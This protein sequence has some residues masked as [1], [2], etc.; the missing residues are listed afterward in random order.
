M[1]KNVDV[2]CAENL[3]QFL[4]DEA[5]D[6][7][8]DRSVDLFNNLRD[9]LEK[10]QDLC[11]YNQIIPQEAESLNEFKFFW[12]YKGLTKN[13]KTFKPK[14]NVLPKPVSHTIGQLIDITQDGSHKKQNLNL[15]VSEYA[16]ESK[17]P[18]LFRAC[19]Y[20]VMDVLRWYKNT[21]DKLK[22]G[23]LTPPL[24]TKS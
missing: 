8:F 23:T 14:E 3:H 11:K 20:L 9:I 5:R 21:E 15:H 1:A 24:Y 16:T 22:E 6:K 12:G 7:S 2:Q 17:S 18:F 19:L 10:I 4:L 13:G